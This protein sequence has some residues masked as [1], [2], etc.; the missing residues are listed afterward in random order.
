V[1]AKIHHTA[2][3]CIVSKALSH[4]S[5]NFAGRLLGFSERPV[6]DSPDDV[7]CFCVLWYEVV[8]VEVPEVEVLE[9]EVLEVE[10][11]EVEVLEVEVLEVEV[12]EVL[13]VL[14]VKLQHKAWK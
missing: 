11:L 14:H 5:H 4:C 2:V 3:V 10:V 12:L 9:V 13:N 7:M 6:A 1:S 8:A